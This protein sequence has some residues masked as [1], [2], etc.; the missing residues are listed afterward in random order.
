[1]LP[2]TNACE[3]CARYSI[4]RLP[5][6]HFLLL[7]LERIKLGT[8]WKT[9]VFILPSI[10]C[11]PSSLIPWIGRLPYFILSSTQIMDTLLTDT[12]GRLPYYYFLL[13][14]TFRLDCVD[15]W[16]TAVLLLPFTP[17]RE[18]FPTSEIGRL[19]YYYFLLL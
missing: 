18:V 9:A 4:G 17:E 13:L 19:P 6:L 3:R 5:Y 15:D 10:S 12:I 8:D 7:E 16:K 1:M 11:C 14:P 2:F